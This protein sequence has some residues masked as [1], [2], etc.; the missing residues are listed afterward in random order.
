[1]PS[2]ILRKQK[3]LKIENGTRSTEYICVLYS[4]LLMSSHRIKC[5]T[6]ALFD[7]KL[8][9]HLVN[10]DMGHQHPDIHGR[11]GGCVFQSVHK[12]TVRVFTVP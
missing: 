3:Q 9:L 4:L 1:M 8:H 5:S 6:P 2:N 7:S 12:S 10:G 11:F